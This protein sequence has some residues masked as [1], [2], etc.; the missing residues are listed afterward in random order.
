MYI[1]CDNIADQWFGLVWVI[2]RQWSPNVQNCSAKLS[3]S[4]RNGLNLIIIFS[5]SR[6]TLTEQS[7]LFFV[8]DLSRQPQGMWL[9][10]KSINFLYALHKVRLR[11]DITTTSRLHAFPTHPRY[12]CVARRCDHS[13]F[14][15]YINKLYQA[16]VAQ[17]NP[18]IIP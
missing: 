4:V 7:Y 16:D 1:R 10:V 17:I 18:R 15:K 11:Q 2:H 14:S 3:L 9:H 6:N 8:H 13:R 5:L 12:A